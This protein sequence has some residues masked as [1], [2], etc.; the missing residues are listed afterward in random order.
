TVPC[1]RSSRRD[2]CCVRPWPPAHVVKDRADASLGGLD[3]RQVE[4][5]LVV[6]LPK[7]QAEYP[8]AIRRQESLHLVENFERNGGAIDLPE[9]PVHLAVA[10]ALF[11]QPPTKLIE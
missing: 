10:I 6:S 9:E 11:G 1:E 7:P 2:E 5:L 3:N 8:V 4:V